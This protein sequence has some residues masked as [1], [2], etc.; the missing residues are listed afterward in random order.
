MN[1]MFNTT[2]LNDELQALKID[3]SRLLNTT[4]EGIRDTASA[5]AD[6]LAARIKEALEELSEVLSDEE[7]QARQLISERPITSLASAFALGVVVSF[8]MR[9]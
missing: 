3:M 9:K 8:A 7:G 5:S 6:G 1:A 4:G 2:H